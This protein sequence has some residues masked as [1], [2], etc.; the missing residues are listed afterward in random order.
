MLQLDDAHYARV[1]L[2]PLCKGLGQLL[3]VRC[4]LE[5]GAEIFKRKGEGKIHGAQQDREKEIIGRE[6]EGK[7]ARSTSLIYRY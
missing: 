5:P 3:S 6:R 4:A 7:N 1:L 2:C